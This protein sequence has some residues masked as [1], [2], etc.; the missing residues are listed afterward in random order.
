MHKHLLIIFAL[1][2]C[3]LT[4]AQDKPKGPD[5]QTIDDGFFDPT[6]KDIEKEEY[7]FGVE[8]RLEIGYVQ[9]EQRT[10]NNTY[11]HMYLHGGRIGATFTFLLPEHFSL[12]T[13]LLYSLTT[14][15][16]EQ[17]YG[18][19]SLSADMEQYISH[20]IMEHNLVIPIRA[21]Y[22]IPLWKKLNLFFYAGPQLQIGL[23]QPSKVTPH[24]SD[25]NLQTYQK[26]GIHVA[27]HDRYSSDLVRANIQ[28]GLGGGFEWD[29][30]RLQLG[31]DFGLNNLVRNKIISSQYMSEWGWY[32][33]L[34]YR[35]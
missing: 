9:N 11:P 13:G 16:S 20:S 28:M 27:D 32:A 24:L 34:C 23:A 3:A 5:L 26:M 12:E 4:Y 30:F 1:C 25:T 14:N 29:R 22:V 7:H 15:K 6:K 17:H 10:R 18:P 31:Y 8:Y 33:S 19:D 2:A 21:F 35:F